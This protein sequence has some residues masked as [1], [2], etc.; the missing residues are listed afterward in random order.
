VKLL[1]TPEAASKLGVTVSRVQALIAEHRLPAQKLGRDFMVREEDLRLVSARQAGRTPARIQLDY[2]TA[3]AEYLRRRKSFLNPPDPKA[4]RYM[5]LETT[6]G[7]RLA[8]SLHLKD[9]QIWVDLTLGRGAKRYFDRLEKDRDAIERQI[10]A[11]LEWVPRSQGVESWI[12]IRMRADATDRSDW[13]R[14]HAWL[15]GYSEAFSRV[16]RPKLLKFR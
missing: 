7:C 10:G 2:W 3:F 9:S 12:L 11:E 1:T 4:Q 15:L 13:A 16:F 5:V 14:Q 8:A 6:R